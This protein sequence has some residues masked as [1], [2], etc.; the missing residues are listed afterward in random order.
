MDVLQ[1]VEVRIAIFAL[2]PLGFLVGHT[3]LGCCGG[4]YQTR[5][6][7]PILPATAVLAAAY[8]CRA[9]SARTSGKIGKESLPADGKFVL[10]GDAVSA[11]DTSRSATCAMLL[12]YGSLHTLFYGVLYGPMFADLDF[13]VVG[14]IAGVLRSTYYA[15]PDRETFEIILRFMEHFGLARK[16]A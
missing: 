11:A 9:G 1:S 15:P 2:W 7:L 16:A 5:F 3:L 6:L 14:V 10:G 8:V 4:T 12:C 13:S